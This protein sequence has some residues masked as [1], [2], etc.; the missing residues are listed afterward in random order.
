MPENLPGPYEIEFTL[1]GWTTPT[2]EHVFRV[3]VAALGSPAFGTLPTAI[4]IQKMGGSTAK[5]NVVANQMWE[6]LRLF[7]N[8]TI[9]CTGYQLWKYVP[10]T[11]GKD[12]VS[13]GAVTNPAASGAVGEIAGQLTQ[14]YRSAN[15]GIMKLVLLETNQTG[16]AKVTLVPNVAGTASQRLAAYIMSA[17]NVVLARDD[18]Y[19][20]NSLRDS[21]GQ[22]ERIWR[23]IFR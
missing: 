3:S 6:F 20:V 4:D 9:T 17:D 11:L 5:L 14:T 16:N 1:T 23:L 2:R 12:F 18:A 15:G 22:N 13:T 21:R 19:P 10:G 8:T 7:W